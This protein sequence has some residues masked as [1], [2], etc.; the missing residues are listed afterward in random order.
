ME[1]L[2]KVTELDGM[3]VR[4]HIPLDKAVSTG[5]IYDV[6][7]TIA[8]AD[9]SVLIKAATEN[10]VIANALRL[11]TA[12]SVKIIYLRVNPSLHM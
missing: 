6:D 10:N 1:P 11:G 2:R 5:V 7:K 12:Q 4:P 3:Q 9:L 8:Y